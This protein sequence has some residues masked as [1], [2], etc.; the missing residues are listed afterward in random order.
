MHLFFPERRNGSHFLQKVGRVV[1]VYRPRRGK[2]W[3][4]E[5]GARE[6]KRRGGR[7]GGKCDTVFALQP[8]TKN[9]KGKKVASGLYLEDGVIGIRNVLKGGVDFPGGGGIVRQLWPSTNIE[10]VRLFLFR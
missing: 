4:G 10:D 6:L 1:R 7:G 8:P 2:G 9:A 3:E 5:E